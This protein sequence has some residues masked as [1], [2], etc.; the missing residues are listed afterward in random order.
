MLSEQAFAFITPD[1]DVIAAHR[2]QNADGTPGGWVASTAFVHPSAI[3]DVDA[4]IGPG[5]VINSPLVILP[6]PRAA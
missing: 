5:M 4:L 1:G 3:V 6:A 2:H